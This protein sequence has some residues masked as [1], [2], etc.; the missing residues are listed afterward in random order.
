M[1]LSDVKTNLLPNKHDYVV[2]CAIYDTE[3][4]TKFNPINCEKP[5]TLPVLKQLDDK[6]SLQAYITTYNKCYVCYSSSMLLFK[7]FGRK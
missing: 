2:Y 4:Q 6:G 5:H 1:F 7:E 3:L